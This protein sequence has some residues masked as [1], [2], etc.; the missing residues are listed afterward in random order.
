MLG[1][2][3]SDP[4][5][6]HLVCYSKTALQEQRQKRSKKDKRQTPDDVISVPGSRQTWRV[7]TLGLPNH[8]GKIS[9]SVV[10][11]GLG[12][13]SATCFCKLHYS[14]QLFPPPASASAHHPHFYLLNRKAFRSQLKGHHPSSM[15]T[16]L[17]PFFANSPLPP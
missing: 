17:S 16:F 8:G 12:V 7:S 3:D 4:A 9:S 10:Q 1:E 13:V 5:V 6:G 2:G 15:K 14:S 11:S